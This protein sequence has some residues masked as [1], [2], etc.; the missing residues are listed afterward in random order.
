MPFAWEKKLI[1]PYTLKDQEKKIKKLKMSEGKK[2]QRPEHIQ[3][4]QRLKKKIEK[5][6]ENKSQLFVK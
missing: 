3:M 4:K 5:M 2:Q 1:S 6:N